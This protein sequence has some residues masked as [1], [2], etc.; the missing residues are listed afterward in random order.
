MGFELPSALIGLLLVG[1]PLVAHLIRRHDLPETRLPTVR[2]LARAVAESQR[3][4]RVTNLLLLL[5][6]MAAVALAALGVTAPYVLVP[7]AEGDGQRTALALVVDDSRSMMAEGDHGPLLERAIERARRAIGALPEGSTATVIL[8]GAP[9]R[10][11]VRGSS[12]L[13]AAAAALASVGAETARPGALPQ[14]I[15]LATQALHTA[16]P[17]VRRL[18]VL[19][20]FAEHEHPGEIRWP[21]E[22]IEVEPIWLRPTSRVNRRVFLA[23][24]TVDPNDPRTL[25]VRAQVLSDGNEPKTR[26]R[27]EQD[28]VVLDE[29]EVSLNDG[30]GTAVLAARLAND[31]HED[32]DSAGATVATLRIEGDDALAADDVAAVLL[33]APQGTRVLLVNGDPRPMPAEDEVGFA[34]RAIGLGEGE[35]MGRFRARVVDPG[36]VG[37]SDLEWADVVVLANVAL[38]PGRFADQL[39]R[40]VESGTGLLVTGG[41]RVQPTGADAALGDALPARIEVASTARAEPGLFAAGA[42]GSARAALPGLGNVRFTRRH[43]LEPRVGAARVEMVFADGAP[44]LVSAEHGRGRVSVFALPLDDDFGDLPYRPGYLPMLAELLGALGGE[45]AATGEQTTPGEAVDLARFTRLGPLDVVSPSGQRRT[46]GDDGDGVLRE[47]AEA[48]VYRLER[49]GRQLPEASFIVQA[50]LEESD[51]ASDGAPGVDT[52]VARAASGGTLRRPLGPL[53]FLLAASLFALEGL[54]RQRWPRLRRR[55]RASAPTGIATAS[56]ATRRAE[57]SSERGDERASA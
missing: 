27:L 17:G 46:L 51:L 41:D 56:R 10:T 30:A 34:V 8:A 7:V 42:N 20:D 48:G 54:L 28:G 13:A 29:A 43:E 26:V 9:P 49:A 39:L 18:V 31:E 55:A 40:A 14:A 35:R 5:L 22:G 25:L 36:V 15:A 23:D 38:G 53:C 24:R 33:R 3:R 12:D 19:S 44:A 45:L 50:P 21:S 11:L 52:T 37:V 16:P 6:R 1:G 2:F 4:R 47:T 32:P 57:P